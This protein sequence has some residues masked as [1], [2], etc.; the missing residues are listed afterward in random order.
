MAGLNMLQLMAKFELFLLVSAF[1]LSKS[2][3]LLTV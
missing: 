2:A 1:T 3:L